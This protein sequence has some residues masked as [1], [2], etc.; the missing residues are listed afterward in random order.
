MKTG[1]AYDDVLIVPT[2][3]PVDS[4]S[5]VSLQTTLCEGLTLDIPF[6]SAPMDT[7]TGPEMAQAMADAGGMG[8]LHRSDIE[9][10]DQVAAISSVDGPVVG[11]VGIDGTPVSDAVE[12]ETAG[13]AAICVDIAH[14]HM[15]RC[16]DVITAIDE[17]IT[18]PIIAGNVATSHGALDMVSAGAD[19]VKVGIGP[20]S[21]CTTR[22]VTGVGFPQ[23]T[24]VQEVVAAVGDTVGV[25]ADGGIR[26]SGDVSRAL[27]VGADAVMIGGLF[28]QCTE[29][30]APSRREENGE[31]VKVIRGMASEEARVA[32]DLLDP[33][34]E[35]AVE[36]AETERP[37]IGPVN[38]LL[39]DFS[40]GVRSA[41][42]YVGA[43]DIEEAQRNA[44][45]VRVT[46]S[47]VERNGVHSSVYQG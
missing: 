26:K 11:T 34:N 45:F 18:V 6:V 20:G 43:Y 15:E 32:N 14:G 3:S 21:H 44:D 7:V 27:C 8:F 40:A 24:A 22:E 28:G 25:I 39:D 36:G 9:G 17:V 30:P 13:A 12:L 1:L 37:E 29:S 38:R 2:R 46:P 47:T 42:S 33:E 4:R 19:V 10:Y 5:E 16:L 35:E 31:L 23:F 41:F